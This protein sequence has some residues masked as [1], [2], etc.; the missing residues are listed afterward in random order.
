MKC[1]AFIQTWIDIKYV[2][3]SKV[4]TTAVNMIYFE[5]QSP[6]KAWLHSFLCCQQIHEKLKKTLAKFATFDSI[7]GRLIIHLW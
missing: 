5:K 1:K 2:G 7:P 3:G 4:K 6:D